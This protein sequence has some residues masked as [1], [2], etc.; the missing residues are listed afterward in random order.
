M[1]SGIV[2]FFNGWLREIFISSTESLWEIFISS[3]EILW[4][5]FYSSTNLHFRNAWNLIFLILSIVFIH[6]VCDK[7]S[8]IYNPDPNEHNRQLLAKLWD[9]VK[10]RGDGNVIVHVLNAGDLRG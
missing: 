1:F 8:N 3:T 5:L 2:L 10:R 7:M 4:G 9:A 6:K